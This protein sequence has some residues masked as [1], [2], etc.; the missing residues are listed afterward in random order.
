MK[1]MG[2]LKVEIIRWQ[3]DQCLF[4]KCTQ[5]ELQTIVKV[6]LAVHFYQLSLS[7]ICKQ[8]SSVDILT[9]IFLFENKLQHKTYLT[10]IRS[11]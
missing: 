5:N 3:V 2:S 9:E 11:E 7:K 6:T 4:P 10:N 8:Y 1:Y